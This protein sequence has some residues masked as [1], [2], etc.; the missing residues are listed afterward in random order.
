LCEIPAD[1]LSSCTAA[2]GKK[3]LNECGA[4]QS[5]YAV[6]QSDVRDHGPSGGVAIQ[7]AVHLRSLHS[8]PAGG[9]RGPRFCR[10]KPSMLIGTQER[11]HRLHHARKSK[12]LF[13]TPVGNAKRLC[14]HRDRRGLA[15]RAAPPYSR[16]SRFGVRL[17]LVL[18]HRASAVVETAGSPRRR[19]FL[20]LLVAPID[21]ALNPAAGLS[22]SAA[23]L[24]G[25]W[26]GIS[27][28]APSKE[29]RR[30]CSVAASRRRRAARPSRS[31]MKHGRG[32]C[33]GG[34]AA[35]RSSQSRRG[36]TVYPLNREETP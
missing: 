34:S 16:Q 26:A 15:A 32:A 18:R 7:Q 20:V 33:S 19:L 28:R 31:P 8:K 27:L 2:L 21:V 10:S 11:P 17:A 5:Q 24:T 14:P 3:V 9:S 36:R 6:N 1:S 30:R 29:S 35:M 13:R 25:P 23:R 4:R 22:H 12:A